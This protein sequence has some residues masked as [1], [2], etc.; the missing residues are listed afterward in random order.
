MIIAVLVAWLIPLTACRQ[1]V[2][3]DVNSELMEAAEDGE[4]ERVKT[5]LAAGA[6]VNTKDD[7]G[8][9]PLMWATAQGHTYTVQVLLDAGA[10]LE[11]KDQSGLSALALAALQGQTDTLKTLLDAGAELDARAGVADSTALMYAVFEGHNETVQALLEAGADVN[12]KNEEDATALTLAA[13]QG[14]RVFL[15]LCVHIRTSFQ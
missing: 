3:Q 8:G 10:Q 6:D 13:F 7:E 2:V 4:A 9:T 15:I 1:D 14:G 12:T 5:L 11:T